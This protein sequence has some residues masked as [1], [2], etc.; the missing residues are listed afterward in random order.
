MTR[1]EYMTLIKEVFPNATNVEINELLPSTNQVSLHNVLGFTS[2]D[3]DKLKVFSFAYSSSINY[4][5]FTTKSIT[6]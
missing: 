6:E 4:L 5:T 3:M 2:A 1:Q